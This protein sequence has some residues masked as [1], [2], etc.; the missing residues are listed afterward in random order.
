MLN[1]FDLGA[2]YP[3]YTGT[4]EGRVDPISKKT[5]IPAYA[6]A[7]K[8]I[9]E[10][11]GYKRYF[12]KAENAWH[13]VVDNT[14]QE[15]WDADGT[16]HVIK[17]LGEEV[18]EGALLEKPVIPP[19]VEEQVVKVQ[20][21]CKARIYAKWDADQQWNALAG[22]S[23]YTDEDLVNCKAWVDECRSARDA[24][25]ADEAT[26]VTIDVTDDKYWPVAVS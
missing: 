22:V 5:L 9:Q 24:L 11:A 21:Q 12:K 15:Y 19:T 6:T 23:G 3:L 7:V 18:P 14:G 4:L 25:L 8:L 17:E 13:Y 1:T 10:K 20:A 16:K 2:K 26:L